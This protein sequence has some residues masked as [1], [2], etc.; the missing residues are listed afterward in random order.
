M[1]LEF[2]LLY[3]TF[4]KDILTDLAIEEVNIPGY[5]DSWTAHKVSFISSPIS[6][7]CLRKETMFHACSGKPSA[8]RNL[9][10]NLVK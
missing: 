10:H 5:S 4:L 6:Y 1:T 2:L 7:N 3:F 9:L 8:R